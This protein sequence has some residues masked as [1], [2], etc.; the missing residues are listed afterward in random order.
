MVDV[1]YDFSVFIRINIQK[2]SATVLT[3]DSI[4]NTF[5]L[6]GGGSNTK[7][8]LPQIFTLKWIGT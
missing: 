8:G 7:F 3:V 4:D 5:S 6:S 1:I 2:Y